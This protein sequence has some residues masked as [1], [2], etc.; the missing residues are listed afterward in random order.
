MS[1][2]SITCFLSELDFYQEANAAQ[3]EYGNRWRAKEFIAR[4]ERAGMLINSLREPEG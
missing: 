1:V 3:F 4:F 2:R